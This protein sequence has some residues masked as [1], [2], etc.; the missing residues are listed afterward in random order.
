MRVLFYVQYLEGIGHLVRSR[1]IADALAARG[2]QVLL[3]VGGAGIPPFTT[4]A[5]GVD[6]C[7]LPSVH[8]RDGRF[9]VLYRE[10]GTLADAAFKQ[11]RCDR[12]LDVF[13]KFSPDVV[14]TET[15]PFGR[16]SMRFELEPL[17]DA[18]AHAKP[19]PL[20][21]ASVRDILQM[22]LKPE[23]IARQMADFN[24]HFACA[25]VHGDPDFIRIE[26][27]FPPLAAS[28]EK[29]RYTGMVVPRWSAKGARTKGQSAADAVQCDV[30]VSGGG[31]A[32]GVQVLRSALA[33]KPETVLKDAVWHAV[34][35]PRMDS[36]DFQDLKDLGRRVGVRVERFHSDLVSV[37]EGA[38]L[39]VQRAGYNTTADLLMTDCRGV[40]VPDSADG[41]QEQ[42]MRAAR[43]QDLGRVVVVDEDRLD[44][45]TMMRG[46]NRAMALP[47]RPVRVDANGA[48]KRANLIVDLWHAR[49]AKAGEPRTG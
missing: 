26:E 19:K 31:G 30:L 25:L 15:F 38:Q 39:S 2:A 11:H 36:H 21:V 44:G 18:V 13:R 4:P 24:A 10:D 5:A 16:W 42:P 6:V 48:K 33:A 22:S 8:A 41:E 29:C 14:V 47:C 12:L 28:L 49:H 9:S 27:S 1:R 35:G 32:I 17:V 20:L 37:M 43:L 45:E 34:T 46:I 3:V 23:K 40:V 7:L